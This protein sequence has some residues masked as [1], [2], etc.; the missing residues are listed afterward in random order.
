MISTSRR[1]MRWDTTQLRR[2]QA[3]QRRAVRGQGDDGRVA[4][5]KAVVASLKAFPVVNLLARRRRPR[6]Q[7]LLQ[8]R[9]RRPQPTASSSPSSRAPDSKGILEVATDLTATLS[10]KARDGK[11]AKAARHRRRDRSR[12]PR[13]AGSAEPASR[14]SSTLPEVAY[15]PAPQSKVWN[16]TSLSTPRCSSQPTRASRASSRGRRR[17]ASSSPSRPAPRPPRPR[18]RA[19]PRPALGRRCWCFRFA[20]SGRPIPP[21]VA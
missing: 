6:P 17:P 3:H 8:H 21:D 9:L 19:R 20:Q 16:S 13:W 15:V 7:A 14:R 5:V 4:A 2:S 11:L 12:S 18:G 10:K 1:R